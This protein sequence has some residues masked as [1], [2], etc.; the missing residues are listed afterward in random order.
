MPGKSKKILFSVPEELLYE[1]DAAAAREHRSRS[2][3]IREATRRY[4][5]EQ[6]GGKRP[7]DD[8]KVREAVRHMDEFRRTWK[9]PFDSTEFIRKMRDTLAKYG[10]DS[11]EF[12]KLMERD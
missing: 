5:A 2:D 3:L 11:E 9:E 6:P 10:R 1:I 4:I 7:I 12:R 8:P